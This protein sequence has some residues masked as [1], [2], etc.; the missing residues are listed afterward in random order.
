MTRRHIT[1]PTEIASLSKLLLQGLDLYLD[2]FE[3]R[4]SENVQE[5][6]QNESDASRGRRDFSPR[7][8]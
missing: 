3:E 7:D 8:C 1:D 4:N 2:Q 5:K 6:S